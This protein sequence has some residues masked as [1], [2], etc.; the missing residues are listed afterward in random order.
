[1]NK[2]NYQLTG[3]EVNTLVCRSFGDAYFPLFD[4][5]RKSGEPT[6]SRLGDTMEVLN[7]KTVITDPK[8]RCI[9][10]FKRNSNIFFHLAESLWVLAGR[11]DLEF[12][13]LFNSRFADSSDDG[14]ILHGAYGNRLR[15][16]SQDQ[17][18]TICSLLNR[19]P[20]LRRSVVSLWDAAADLAKPFKDVPCNTQLMFRVKGNHLYA[21]VIN[22][23]NDLHWGVPANVFQFSMLGE[24]MALLL[25]KQYSGQT[26]LALSLHYYLDNELNGILSSSELQEVFYDLYPDSE[27]LFHFNH[28][29]DNFEERFLEI[30]RVIRQIPELVLTCSRDATRTFEGSLAELDDLREKSPSFFEI[31]YL[32]LLYADYKKGLTAGK[33]AEALRQSCFERLSGQDFRHRDFWALGLNFFAAR[34]KNKAFIKDSGILDLHLGDY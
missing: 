26:H 28:S 25:E 18:F 14:K 27:L 2:S 15:N 10:A 32:L 23:S 29:L 3:G 13:G 1:M 31:A 9:A 22:R 5:L 4:Y 17:L 11:N 16:G 19:V 20:D 34:L 24:V 8:K 7:F 6:G 30:D 12:I 33:P 21:T